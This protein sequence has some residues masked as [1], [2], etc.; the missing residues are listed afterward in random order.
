MSPGTLR[1]LRGK[2]EGPPAVKLGGKVWYR[3][4]GVLTWLEKR[5]K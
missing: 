5:E 4:E 2:G 1:N 3:P